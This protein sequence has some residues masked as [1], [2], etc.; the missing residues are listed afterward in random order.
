[1]YVVYAFLENALYVRMYCTVCYAQYLVLY[2]NA[3]VEKEWDIGQSTCSYC[4][5]VICAT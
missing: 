1:M 3:L 5:V 4:Q 2:R